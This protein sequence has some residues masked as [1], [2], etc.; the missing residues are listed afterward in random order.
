MN[1]VCV[2]CGSSGGRNPAY[3]KAA[4]ALGTC[5]AQRGVRLVYG[6]GGRGMMGAV[7]DAAVAGGGATLGVIPEGLFKREGLH[8]GLDEL[9]VVSSM[10]ERKA[11]MAAE[12]DA[13]VAL[14]GGIGTMEE[15]FEIW[16]WT[17]IGVHAKPC[18]ILNV[19]G[20]Y[21]GLLAFLDNMVS[22]QF[23]QPIHRDV[24]L[25]DDDPERLLGRVLSHR[26]QVHERWMTSEQI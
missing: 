3:L 25:V 1:S 23:V 12:A 11:L 6:G 2:F 15:L 18:G 26:P 8:I 21:D 16:T 24:V 22:E 14:P 4:T 10:H 5:I 20:Y 17:Q 7:A 13:F 19:A 9:R